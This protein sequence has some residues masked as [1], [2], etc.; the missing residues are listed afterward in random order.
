MFLFTY[1][2]GCRALSRRSDGSGSSFGW[3][4]RSLWPARPGNNEVEKSA[5]KQYDRARPV[6]REAQ[7]N[8]TELGSRTLRT[9]F[10]HAHSDF[11]LVRASSSCPACHSGLLLHQL[12]PSRRVNT[13]TSIGVRRCTLNTRP[14]IQHRLSLVGPHVAT[15]NAGDPLLSVSVKDSH[16]RHW[17]GSGQQHGE[18]CK[19]NLC[20]CAARLVSSGTVPLSW[21]YRGA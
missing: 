6:P 12:P 8:S 10:A 13:V 19:A 20:H 11:L 18:L 2:W 17:C 16:E 14:I 21:R 9:L 7:Q 1:S 4:P 3:K 5:A 15:G